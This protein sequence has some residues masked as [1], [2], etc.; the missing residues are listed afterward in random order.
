MDLDIQG[1]DG[2]QIDN[3]SLL[4]LLDPCRKD[5]CGCSLDVD[6]AVF[7]KRHTRKATARKMRVSHVI[8]SYGVGFH[9]QIS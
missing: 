4:E 1:L 8:T 9:K 7:E 6:A 3:G 5:Q 2:L